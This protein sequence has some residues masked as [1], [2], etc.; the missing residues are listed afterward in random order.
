MTAFSTVGCILLNGMK[1]RIITIFLCLGFYSVFSQC[2]TVPVVEAVRNGDFEA[3]YLP[4]SIIGSPVNSHNYT[5]GGIYDF[6]SDLRY[7]G[8]WKAPNNACLWGMAD[9][10]AVGRVEKTTNTC[11]AG[12]AIVYGRYTGANRYK[13]HKPIVKRSPQTQKIH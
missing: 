3:G 11:G 12:N 4:G 2:T 13:D 7:S 1:K 5:P 8:E 10:Y 6:Q 9:Q